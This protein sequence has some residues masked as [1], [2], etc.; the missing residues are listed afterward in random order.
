[1]NADHTYHIPVLVNEC[2]EALAIQ[3]HGVYVD[4]TVGGGGHFRR[5]VAELDSRGTAVG[6]DRDATAI[7]WC[8]EHV[9]Q[10][11]C[12]VILEQ[13]PFSR[14]DAVLDKHGIRA[15]DGLLLDLGV[16]S[17][18][19]DDACRG[20][21]YMQQADLDMR[22]DPSSAV[23]AAGILADSDEH[24][25]ARI[26][27]E[28]GEI[29]NPARMARAFKRF[30]ARTSMKTSRDLIRCLHEE[31]GPAI[32][33]KVIAKV[34]QAVRIAVNDELSELETCLRK[35][36]SYVKKSG[37]IAVISYHSLEDR[38]VK[39]FFRDNEHPCRCPPAIPFCACGKQQTL[40]RINNK[41]IIPSMSEVQSNARARSARLRVAEK[42]GI[43]S[44]KTDA[45][46]I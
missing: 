18:Q 2:I 16:S 42:V 7:A 44:G 13:S 38:I 22:M 20:F 25:L 32:S 37:R 17:R 30:Q 43:T 19:I 4:A 15:I 31:Y 6:I 1:L 5:L 21:S 35:A 27:S 8:R 3:P 24:E 40:K 11:H 34:F 9:P 29:I 39:N 10:A 12:A 33:V 46:A 26:F 28:Y 45:Q 23:A 36:I 14:L 41:V